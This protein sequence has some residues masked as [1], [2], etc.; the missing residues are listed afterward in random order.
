MT[1]ITK[2]APRDESLTEAEADIV[3]EL[4][5]LIVEGY[6]D[7]AARIGASF[8]AAAP[9]RAAALR[10]AHALLRMVAQELEGGHA[11]LD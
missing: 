8:V 9:S 1:H 6:D 11:N 3:A 4:H 7:I 10:R 2:S 5:M